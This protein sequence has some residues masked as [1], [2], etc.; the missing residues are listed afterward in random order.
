MLLTFKKG[1]FFTKRPV[2][3]FA[4]HYESRFGWPVIYNCLMNDIDAILL[5]LANPFGCTATVYEF[6][7]LFDPTY[8]NIDPNDPEGWK[9]YAEKVR[10]CMAK[11]LGVEKIN[12]GVKCSFD[13]ERTYNEKLRQ[14]AARLGYGKAGKPAGKPK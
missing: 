7:E 6:E 8:L 13:A 10:D 11:C 14:I 3:V 12:G 1:A 4:I 9:I 2:K 5:A